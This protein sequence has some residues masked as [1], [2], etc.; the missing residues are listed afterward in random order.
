MGENEPRE[1][2]DRGALER[3]ADFVRRLEAVM[4]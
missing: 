3:Y 1:P 2:P 4:N